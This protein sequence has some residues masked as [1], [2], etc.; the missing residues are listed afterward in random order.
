[1]KNIVVVPTYNEAGNVAGIIQVVLAHGSDW[2]VLIVD[3]NSPDGTGKIVDEL[4]QREGR[5][6]VLHRKGK[7][8]FGTAYRDGL[9]RALEIGS[10][11]ACMMDSDFHTIRRCFRGFVQWLK[12]AEPRT[13]RDMRQ[14]AAL[15]IGV[16]PVRFI[17]KSPTC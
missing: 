16:G 13:D 4:A 9:V 15:V 8:G 10:D 3:D 7:L 12:P 14:E 11:Y 5:V 6:S 1:M 2:G 17:A